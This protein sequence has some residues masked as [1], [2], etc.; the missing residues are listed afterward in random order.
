MLLNIISG[1]F[2]E[3]LPERER[4]FIVFGLDAHCP[5]LFG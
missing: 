5:I 1:V 2:V 4:L 3:Y